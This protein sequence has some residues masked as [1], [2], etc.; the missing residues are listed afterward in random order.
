MEMAEKKDI[1]KLELEQLRAEVQELGEKAFRGNQV[2][3]WLW[4][5]SAKSFGEM[6]NL[7]ASF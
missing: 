5:K 7:S 3:E 2:Y 1:R 4:T 6:T